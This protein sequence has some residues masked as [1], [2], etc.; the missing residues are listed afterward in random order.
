MNGPRYPK[1]EFAR[2]GDAIYDR[3]VAPNVGVEDMGK[4]VLIDIETGA[5]E[6]D[7]DEMAA[8]DRLAARVPDPQPW[9]RRVGSRYAALRAAP[10]DGSPVI[11]GV[12]SDELDAT[13]RLKVCGVSGDLLEIDAVID[14]GFDGSLSLPKSLIAGLGLIWRRTGQALLANGAVSDF[15]IH[16]GIV[17][18]DGEPRRVL[19][20][21]VEAMPLIGMSLLRGYE[22]NVQ[23]RPSGQVRIQELPG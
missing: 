21:E 3:D 11:E 1:E 15:E 20:D 7:A 17:V 4:F 16:E 9:L 2:R 13:V 8:A 22:L 10:L 5:F 23:I 6:I 19:V 14:T 12:V 18:W